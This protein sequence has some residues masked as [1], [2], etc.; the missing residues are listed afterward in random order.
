LPQSV[1]LR[2]QAL[3]PCLSDLVVTDEQKSV[4]IDRTCRLAFVA[5]DA[6]AGGRGVID[7]DRRRSGPRDRIQATGVFSMIVAEEISVGQDAAAGVVGQLIVDAGNPSHMHRADLFS[8]LEM[9]A[10]VG[11]A[12]NKAFHTITVIDLAGAVMQ[13]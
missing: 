4:L 10:G 12:A 13:R 3:L 9:F 5:P 11:C 6:D 7:R 8:P 2:W 1:F